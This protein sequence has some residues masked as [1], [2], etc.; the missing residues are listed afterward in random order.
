MEADKA[1]DSKGV[2]DGVTVQ[3]NGS[4]SDRDSRIV[5][6]RLRLL[7]TADV[8]KLSVIINEIE[9]LQSRIADLATMEFAVEDLTDPDKEF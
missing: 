7:I 2:W 3:A 8:K 1:A 9:K 6:K 4:M 5:R